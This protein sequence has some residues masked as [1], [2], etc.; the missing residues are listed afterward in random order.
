MKL[1]PKKHWRQK[2][3]R[4]QY[5]QRAKEDGYRARSVYKLEEIHNK[6]RV[7]RKTDQVLDV[8]AAP[9][10]WS[11]FAHKMV[12]ERGRVIA[13]DLKEIEPIEGVDMIEGDIRDPAVIEQVHALVGEKPFNTVISDIAPNTSGIRHM[14]HVRSIE[15]SLFALT[16]AIDLLRPGGNFVTKVFM[17]GEF[18]LLLKLTRRYFR[19]VN[20]FNPNSKRKES[21]ETFIVA[22]GLKAKAELNPDLELSVLLKVEP[23]LFNKK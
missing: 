13:I 18:D 7:L 22:K 12:G 8:G 1:K 20:V 14:D 2:Q 9:G 17:G 3:G 10:S 15:L 19:N 21:K 5:F 6:F 16:T 11:Q 23:Q 4:D